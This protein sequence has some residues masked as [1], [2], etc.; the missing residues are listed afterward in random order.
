MVEYRKYGFAIQGIV[1][2]NRSPSCGV[3]TTS[4]ENREV[5]GEGVFMEALRHALDEHA[6]RVEIIGI[7]AF[8]TEQAVITLKNLLNTGFKQN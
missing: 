2:I 8:E 4:K 5:P 3:E 1:G 6:L 7:K